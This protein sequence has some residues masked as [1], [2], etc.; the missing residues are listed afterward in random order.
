MLTQAELMSILHY[1]PETGIF[2]RL[3]DRGNRAKA[4]TIAGCKNKLGYFVIRINDKLYLSHRLAWLYMNGEFPSKEIDH[5]D[6]DK[7]NTT[8]K[9]LRIA[10]RSQNGQNIIRPQVNNTTGYLGVSRAERNAKKFKA[11]IMI[12]RTHYQLGTFDTA[13]E[14]HEAYK[15]AKR[16]L[17]PFGT[18]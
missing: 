8:W 14:A 15:K 12:N 17:H 2:T 5:I 7:S 13:V 16:E 1:N 18:I 6:N 4:G 11:T 9:N 10:N 3:V